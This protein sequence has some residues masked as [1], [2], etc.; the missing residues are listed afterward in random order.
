MSVSDS[1]IEKK[2]SDQNSP[3]HILHLSLLIESKG[4]PLYLEALEIIARRNLDRT[5][6]AILCGPITFSPYCKQFTSV[7]DK[8]MWIERK[9]ELINRISNGLLTVEWIPGATGKLK[10]KLFEDS[11]IFVF[12][13]S[14]PVEA[15]PIVLLEALATGCSIITSA[16]G[17]IPT[18]L[19][20]R[21]CCI[22]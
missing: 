12:P 22:Y 11:H 4:F 10:Q 5:I 20:P 6:R 1:F 13:S 9:V 2:H 3:V 16:A 21:L 17:E 8:R 19:N 14:F 15:Q 7:E 18:T